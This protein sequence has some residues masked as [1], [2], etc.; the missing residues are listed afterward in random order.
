M[1]ETPKDGNL[2]QRPRPM[3]QWH[4]RL[5]TVVVLVI[6]AAMVRGVDAQPGT[7][8]GIFLDAGPVGM[9]AA[10]TALRARLVHVDF[11]ALDAA[12]VR[13]GVGE[14]AL[15]GFNLFDDTQMSAI[16]DE[17]EPTSS[18]YALLGR[19]EDDELS[20]VTLAVNGSIVAGYVVSARGA[21]EIRSAGRDLTVIR[22]VPPAALRRP[23]ND[24]VRPSDLLPTL[25]GLGSPPGDAGTA[26]APPESG[27]RI[28]VL[29]VYTRHAK[30]E[31]GGGTA[32]GMATAIEA[33]IASI[34]KAYRD[35]RAS[36]RI[37]LVATRQV[38]YDET[39]RSTP[40]VLV[41]L[42]LPADGWMD[43]VH[44]WRN[45][46]AAD[47][48]SL[49]VS[50]EVLIEHWP[51]GGE[52]H[53]PAIAW[54]P[55]FRGL[56]NNSYPLSFWGFNVTYPDPLFLGHELGHNMGLMH[57]RYQARYEG[58]VFDEPEER[59]ARYWY[60][61]G[62]AGPFNN[63][64]DT[65]PCL[66][67]IMAYGS[68]CWDEYRDDTVYLLRFSNPNRRYQGDRTG[69]PGNGPT[70]RLWNGPSNA[71]RHLNSTRRLVAN[72]W[73]APCIRGG[74][75]VRLQASN[76][77]YVVA[78]G[79]GGGAVTADGAGRVPWGR[80]TVVASSAG[81]CLKS[82][83]E[84]SFHTSDGFFIRADLG[85][86]AALDATAP[87]ATPW[88]RFIARLSE[89][90]TG[91]FRSGDMLTLQTWGGHYATAENG[92]GVGVRADEMAPGVPWARFRL[93]RD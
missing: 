85:G 74:D 64:P 20:S 58:E 18:G 57:E 56:W 10:P 39:G 63:R 54:V 90:E 33:S 38:D 12:R 17:T 51:D 1:T 25:L 60:S 44:R 88:A 22:H 79:N 70:R 66:V 49:I 42:T 28:D 26:A 35:S 65:Y 14:R 2:I 23:R 37:H 72:W 82:G 84:V 47:L 83:D 93:L 11:S 77:Q 45:R 40:K 3:R 5:S 21:Y 68:Q 50:D 76:G 7:P 71:V 52:V 16:I 75:T 32:A 31:Y 81:R 53:E 30:R 69:W 59:Y 67:T 55:D 24:A 43:R 62:Y 87:R 80:F 78:V 13:V 86:G 9:A 46:Y 27:R 41:H 36:Q 61:F 34:N 92:G 91:V 6:G 19:L 8:P 73:R 15:L 89:G 4:A 29:V 48:V